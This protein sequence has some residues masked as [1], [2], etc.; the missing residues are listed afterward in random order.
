MRIPIAHQGYPFIGL[1]L[2]AT[3]LFVLLGYTPGWVIFG[4]LTVFVVAFFRD[5]ERQ[6]AGGD[7]T[8]LAPA[9][10]KII[11]IEEKEM[12]P[13]SSARTIKISIFMSV[14]NCHVN[15]VPQKGRVEK[16]VYRPG[17]FY[18]ADQSRA[19]S[20]N[21]QNALLLKTD[22]EQEISIIQVAGLIARRIVCWVKPGQKVARG[23]RF[24]LIRFGSRV[25]LYLPPAVRLRVQRGDKVKG[26]LTII[27]TY[28]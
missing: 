19:S 13:F 22:D 8:L 24:G 3:A 4:M 18:S 17:S 7:K 5:P 2:M 27:G 6:P 20:E 10:G 25:D 16:I 1:G 15:R 26:G 12:S 14:F 21:E 28:D 9:D 11:L 23:E